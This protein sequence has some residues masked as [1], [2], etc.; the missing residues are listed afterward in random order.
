M[1][2]CVNLQLHDIQLTQ[3]KPMLYITTQEGQ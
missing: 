3:A 1:I 2:C